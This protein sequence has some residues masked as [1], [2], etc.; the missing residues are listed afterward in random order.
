MDGCL[1]RDCAFLHD[2][3]AVLADRDQILEKRRK[4]FNYK[5]RPTYRQQMTRY[6][7][8]VDCVAGNDDALRAEIRGSEQMYQDVV[9]DRAYCAN[10][11]YMKPWKKGEDRKPLRACKRCKYTMNCSVSALG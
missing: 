8:V 5:H 1:N 9:S 11:R 3:D 6:V 7:S 10:V 4:T 2:R